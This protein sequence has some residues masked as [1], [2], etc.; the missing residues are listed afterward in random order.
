ML[1]CVSALYRGY[2]DVAVKESRV[3]NS[4]L[5]LSLKDLDSGASLSAVFVDLCLHNMIN[6][7][8]RIALEGRLAYQVVGGAW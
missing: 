3:R 7:G 1:R 4:R 2:R 8:L 6:S 5:I